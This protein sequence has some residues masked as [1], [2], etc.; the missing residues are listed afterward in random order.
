M[1]SFFSAQTKTYIVFVEDD[2][3]SLSKI[4]VTLI[5]AQRSSLNELELLSAIVSFAAV[6]WQSLKAGGILHAREPLTYTASR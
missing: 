1:W 5:I 6:L 2:T 4:I 3:I